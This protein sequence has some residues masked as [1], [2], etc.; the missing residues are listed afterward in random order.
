MQTGKNAA[1]LCEQCNKD[2]FLEAKKLCNMEYVQY[3]NP[4]NGAPAFE[5]L[6]PMTKKKMVDMPTQVGF[7]IK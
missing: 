7:E 4:D 6:V 3:H 1:V 5:H 2:N